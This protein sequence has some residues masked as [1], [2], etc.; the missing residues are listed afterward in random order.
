MSS[1][2]LNYLKSYSNIHIGIIV[3]TTTSFAQ[4]LDITVHKE[5]KRIC[6]QKSVEY[7]NRLVKTLNEI[8]PKGE[9][10]N[11]RLLVL[12]NQVIVAEKDLKRRSK[13]PNTQAYLIQK[14]TVEDIY[15][16]I[17]EAYLYLRSYPELIIKGFIQG[18]Y[19][20]ISSILIN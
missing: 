14:M 5:V 19:V 7:T 15:I 1:K 13:R 6:K 11:D 4:P 2:V 20:K 10:V 16:W 8:M 18:G 12:D 3:G 17:K 9:E